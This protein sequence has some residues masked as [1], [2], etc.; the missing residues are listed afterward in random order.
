M[1]TSYFQ[2]V[3]TRDPSI[4]TRPVLEL[5]GEVI[6][7]EVNESLCKPFTVQEI[8][9]ALF[10][11]GPLKAPRPDGYPARF[12]QRNWN[13]LKHEIIQ[14]VLKFFETGHMPEGVN[15][16]S[17]VLIPK[18]DQPAGLKDFRPISLCN[19]L[20][21]II[22]KC[23]VN[24]L[25]LILGDIISENQSAFV[26]GRLIT[27][28]ALLAFECL[29][30]MEHGV[31]TQN[32]FCAYK[33]DLSKAY[34]RVDWV[35]LEE[36]M[37]KMGFSCRWIRWI[38]SCVTTVRYS[39]KLNGALLEAFSP[40]LGLRQGDPLSPF[41]FLF[42]VDGLSALLQSEISSGGISPIKICRRGLGISH[43]LFAD[44]TL[45]FFKA[46]SDQA[47]RVK[48]VRDIYATA[49]RQLINESK[50]SILF[51]T[52]CGE[53]IQDDVRGILNVQKEEFEDKYLGLPTPEAECLEGN[54]RPCKTSW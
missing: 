6:S 27:D 43:L 7:D 5:F 33:L 54:L 29:Y 34:D 18:I 28:N 14:G 48:G 19:V 53:L 3:Y 51:S 10:Q 35:F 47:T 20:Y 39:V 9:N 49:T 22:S 37:H 42:V 30:Y 36:V 11:I 50:C 44:D 13:V 23:L 26:P 52:G 4:Q 15:E 2:S 17:I 40:T 45:L 31:T 25:R 1:A 8:S 32:P 16:T 38:M 21:K 12:Y 46:N 24:R 41:L